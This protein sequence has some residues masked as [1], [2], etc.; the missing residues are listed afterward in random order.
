MSSQNGPN[1][2]YACT[3]LKEIGAIVHD[4]RDH[5]HSHHIPVAKRK[6]Q[7]RQ[8]EKM[9]MENKEEFIKVFR[10]YFGGS[11]FFFSLSPPP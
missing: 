9:L 4:L 10:H 11:L 7:L 5:F 8:T 6:Q 1:P 3:P 2:E